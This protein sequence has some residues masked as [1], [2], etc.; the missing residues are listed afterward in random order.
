M[1]WPPII[2]GALT[3]GCAEGFIF[4]PG[5]H[6]EQAANERNIKWIVFSPNRSIFLPR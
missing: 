4:V 5:L 3:L 2:A 1:L 6:L